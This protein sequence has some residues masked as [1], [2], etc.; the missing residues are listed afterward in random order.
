MPCHIPTT[1]RTLYR[2]RKGLIFGICRGLA[3]Y[4]DLPVL[5]VQFVM[6]LAAVFTGFWPIVIAYIAAA[7]IIK[8]EPVLPV[9]NAEEAEFYNSYSTGRG[10]A[11]Q[12]LKCTFDTLDR[13]IQRIE[14]IVTSTEFDWDRRFNEEHR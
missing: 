2:S 12:R 8:P 13:R 3:T 14:G 6:I 10:L 5:G 4:F 11:L 9:E 1:T 7:F